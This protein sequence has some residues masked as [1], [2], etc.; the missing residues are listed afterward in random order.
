MVFHL[1][2]FQEV[3]SRAFSLYRPHILAGYLL[4]LCHLFSQFYQKHSILKAENAALRKGR[5]AL[6]GATQRVLQKGMEVLHLPV[7]KVM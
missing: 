7:P 4:D 3:L 1:L 6:V 5:M 2:Q